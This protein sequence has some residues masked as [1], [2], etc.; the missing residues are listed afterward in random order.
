MAAPVSKYPTMAEFQTLLRRHR[1][2]AT[3]QRLAVHEVMMELGHASADLVRDELDRR[4]LAV[5]AASVYNILSQLADHHIYAR[6]LSATNK[7]YFDADSARHVHL[8]DRENH[9]WRDLAPDDELQQLVTAHLKRRK[10]KGY[11]IE[12]IDIQLVAKPT[13]KN[14]IP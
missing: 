12:D 10:F 6:R 9:T 5:T 3:R 4:G 11:T 7:M 14:R 1:L 8:Y 13:R 2:K